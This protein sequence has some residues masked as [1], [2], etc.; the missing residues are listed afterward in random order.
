MTRVANSGGNASD[1]PV[2]APQ[3]SH[4]QILAFPQHWGVIKL[5]F[6]GHRLDQSRRRDLASFVTLRTIFPNAR[7]HL[8]QR[9]RA[10]LIREEG[11]RAEC[12]ERHRIAAGRPGMR[13]L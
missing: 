3:P 5:C 1:R 8:G 12:F 2:T 9:S 7:S 6:E 11:S 13:P 10:D 4:L